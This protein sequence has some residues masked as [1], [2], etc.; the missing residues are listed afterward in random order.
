MEDTFNKD[1]N[2]SSWK[3]VERR[4]PPKKI[5]IFLFFILS[6]LSFFRLFKMTINSSTLPKALHVPR[7][8]THC[9]TTHEEDNLTTKE[10]QFISNLISRKAPCNLLFFGFKPQV[11]GLALLNTKGVTAILEDDE[12]KL[13]RITEQTI[14]VRFFKVKYHEK[15]K[16]A[17]E[18]LKHARE[19]FGCKLEAIKLLEE[20]GCR[21]QIEMPKEVYDKK[22]DVVVVDGPRGDNPETPGRME[23]IYEAGVIARLGNSTDVFVHDVQRTIEKWYSWEF[24][25]HENLISSKGKLWH[26]R[27]EGGSKLTSFCPEV[28]FH[29]L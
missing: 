3:Q 6:A 19:H 9:T 29:I 4:M 16:E 24:L 17:Y 14:G 5:L 22:W 26:F 21:L 7:K 2:I 20:R 18:L 12:E 25:C 23:A 28:K 15:A 1:T 10:Y 13:K 11:L 27:V 8:L